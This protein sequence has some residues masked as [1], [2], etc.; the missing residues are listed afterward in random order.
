MTPETKEWMWLPLT[1]IPQ[2]KSLMQLT[3][4]KKNCY[5]DEVGTTTVM[6]QTESDGFHQTCKELELLSKKKE[7]S[8]EISLRLLA[9]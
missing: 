1:L 6:C 4:T 7:L 5:Q 9:S 2:R 8:E 3:L